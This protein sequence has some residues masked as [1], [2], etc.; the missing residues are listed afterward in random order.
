MSGTAIAQL[1]AVFISPILSRLYTPE[2]FGILALFVSITTVLSV[3][4]TGRYE[5][6]IVLPEQ[7]KDAN[8]L[9]ILSMAIT[10][11]VSVFYLVPVILFKSQI[12]QIFNEPGISQWLIFIPFTV[13]FSGTY[14]TFNYLST[15]HKTF[16][17]NALSKIMKTSATGTISL[18]FGFLKL[19][20]S[21]LLLGF[22]IGQF[23]AAFILAYK[24]IFKIKEKFHAI[25]FADLR[26]I[27]KKYDNFPKFNMPHALLNTLSANFPVLLLS[28]Y[29]PISNIGLYNFSIYV[30]LAPLTLIS[31]S[32]GQVFFQK[33]S[34]LSNSGNIILPSIRRIIKTLGLVGLLP[35]IV[36]VI[37]APDIFRIVFG[38]D[39][40]EAGEYTQLLLPYFFMV[41]IV[42][43]ISFVPAVLEQQKKAFVLEIIYFVLKSVALVI[44]IYYLDFKLALI[45]FSFAGII[46][47]SY[48]L[49]WILR[50]SKKHDI[51]IISPVS[52]N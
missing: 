6:A 31:T 8:K 26:I 9:V 48:N 15:R 24:Y 30:M 23:S 29:F 1:I 19:G 35:L 16:K 2:D 3:I 43:S 38:I 40:V 12:T 14:Q 5:L 37:F 21:G 25:T 18:L 17:K 20:A 28:S 50:I 34:S 41:F 49:F 27:A 32:T 51:S 7:E 22:I 33:I 36:F 13:Y 46:M 11:L 10:V 42:S 4:S 44:G 39:W 52:K 47:L 45:L